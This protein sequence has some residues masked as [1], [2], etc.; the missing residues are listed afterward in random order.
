[1]FSFESTMRSAINLTINSMSAASHEE[2]RMNNVVF[3]KQK[4]RQNRY[5]L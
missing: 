4:G 2:S 1:M 5:N 3:T